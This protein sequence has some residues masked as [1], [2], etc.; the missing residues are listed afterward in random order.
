MI[1]QLAD[2]Y[3]QIEPKY[4]YLRKMM[5]GFDV[6]DSNIGVD[7]FIPIQVTQEEIAAEQAKGESFPNAY[8]ESLAIYRKICESI[9]MEDVFL[10]H[11]SAFA[12]KDKAVL[13]AAPSG[14]G[15][16]T[17]ARLWREY[18]PDDVTM[19]NDDKPLIRWKDD[20]F[21]IY[22]TPWA[23]K[24]HLTN[25]ISVELGCIVI[26]ERGSSNEAVPLS[27]NEAY[28]RLLGQVYRPVSSAE[29]MARTFTFLD[30]LVDKIPVLQLTCDISREAV[31][32]LKKKLDSI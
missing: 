1:I 10:F 14:T 12:Y 15:K 30:A 31:L 8:L 29:K 13:I 22:G 2:L 25:N 7:S 17:H 3:F 4:D 6:P 28:P 19:I 21:V 5:D 18:F 23:G 26:L 20:T 27:K 24:H 16:S 9:V 32:C 11:C